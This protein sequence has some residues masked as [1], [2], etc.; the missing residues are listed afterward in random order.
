MSFPILIIETLAGGRLLVLALV[1]PLLGALLAFS[2]GGRA[3]RRIA[4][5]TAL[6]GLVVAAAIALQLTSSAAALDYAFGGWAPPLGVSLRADGPAVMMLVTTALVIAATMVYA[7]VDFQPA[8]GQREG[9][10]GLV[11]WTLLLALWA[12]LNA[13]FL[14]QDLFNL[15]VALEIL[16]FSAVPLVCLNGRAE[17]IGAA[18]RY[19]L[20]ALLGS[21]LYLL[22]AGLIYGAYGLLDLGLLAARIQA[23]AGAAPPALWL[24]LGLMTAGLMAKTA[25]VPLHLWLPP[26]HSGAPAAASAVLSAL[27]V[28]G[29]FFVLLRLWFDLVPVPAGWLLAQMQGALGAAAILLGGVMA[30][31]QTRL[32][33]MV[34]YSTVAQIGY[35]FLIFPLAGA[36]A[37]VAFITV[38]VALDAGTAALTGGLLQIVSH[39]LAKA[40]MFLA[41]GRIA[42]RLGHDRIDDLGGVGRAMPLTL[43]AFGL[44]GLSLMG[45]PPSGG[46][47]AK[48]LLLRAAVETGQWWWSLAILLGGLLTAGYLFRVLATALREAPDDSAIADARAGTGPAAPGPALAI[49]LLAGLSVL[50]GLVPLGY[51]ELIQIGRPGL[52]QPLGMVP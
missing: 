7:G 23:D 40:A 51:W 13:I 5:V 47:A 2:T 27:V 6:A 45:L 44:A 52:Y 36:D 18:L 50:L 35:L 37:A 33:L 42:A 31:R 14:G 49:L 39:A 22:G 10:S 1:L 25:I 12:A 11:F 21:V 48:W 15:F 24:A 41:A 8:A 29:A 20:F 30:L 26:A 43:L 3:A 19:L 28:K 34:A 16:T 46:F 38:G 4:L 9:R 32:K 17:T